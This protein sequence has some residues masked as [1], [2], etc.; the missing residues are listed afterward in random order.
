MRLYT[1]STSLHI[2]INTQSAAYSKLTTEMV[3]AMQ[4]NKHEVR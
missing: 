4:Q 3:S 1:C 2:F